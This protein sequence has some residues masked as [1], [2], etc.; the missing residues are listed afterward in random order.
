M[1]ANKIFKAIPKTNSKAEYKDNEKNVMDVKIIWLQDDASRNKIQV[2]SKEDNT[3]VLDK[4]CVSFKKFAIAENL[5][6][7]KIRD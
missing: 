5:S 6:L 7:T 3:K 4:I 1:Y 2:I